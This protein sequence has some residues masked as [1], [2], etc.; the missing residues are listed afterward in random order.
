MKDGRAGRNTRIRK[1]YADERGKCSHECT[2]SIH[3]IHSN[4]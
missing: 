1:S 2:L 4:G 3:E